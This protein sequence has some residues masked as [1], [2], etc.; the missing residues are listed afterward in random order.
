M[1]HFFKRILNGQP[2]EV[3]GDGM[4]KRD[5]L[6]IDDLTDGIIKALNKK[7]TGIIQFG[8]GQPTSINDLLTKIRTIVGEER[9]I[10]V[11]YKESR[12]GEIYE[13]WC[14][15]SK[16]Q[17]ELNFAPATS[18]DDGLKRTWSW[19]KENTDLSAT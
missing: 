13:T 9:D 3:F 15:I 1:A 10:E 18:L 2:L 19:F 8:S 11:E 17:S 6:Y 5:F 12:P 4:Q 7:V 14:D 16:A